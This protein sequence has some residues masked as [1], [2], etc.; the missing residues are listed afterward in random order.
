MGK[1]DNPKTIGDCGFFLLERYVGQFPP[2]TPVKQIARFMAHDLLWV[3][4]EPTHSSLL[5]IFGN[6]FQQVRMEGILE[7]KEANKEE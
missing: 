5:A 2:E 7:Q 6:E 3:F 1:V 4:N